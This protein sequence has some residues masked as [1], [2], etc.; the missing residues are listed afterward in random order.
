VLPNPRQRYLINKELKL[1]YGK[2][3]SLTLCFADAKPERAPAGN[4]LPTPKGQGYSLTFRFY[5][6]RGGFADHSFFP[7]PLVRLT[8]SIG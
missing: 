1:Q 5:R 8:P 2:D 4:W 3:G 7:P 6:P